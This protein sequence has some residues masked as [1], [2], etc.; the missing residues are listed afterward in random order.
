[1]KNV[2]S[3]AILLAVSLLAK[4]QSEQ[5]NFSDAFYFV[6]EI[7][8]A[9]LSGRNFRISIAVKEAPA[10]SLSKPRIYAV[11]VRK[12]KEDIIGHTMVY[13]SIKQG[14]WTTYTIEST[15]DPEATRIWFFTAVNGNGHFH[16]DRLRCAITDATGEFQPVDLP[17]SSFEDKKI[18]NGFYKSALDA[19]TTKI[20]LSMQSLDGKQSLEIATT[21]Q[22]PGALQSTALH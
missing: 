2:L 4:S 12:G 22:K 15:I 5:F 10:D 8:T 20:Q 3:L 7:K 16:F 17:N 1:M 9:G 11:Q 6:R 19:S 18:L 21:N 14:D 13:A